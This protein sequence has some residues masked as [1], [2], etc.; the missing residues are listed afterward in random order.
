VGLFDLPLDALERLL[1]EHAP[2]RFAP[3][4]AP[5]S[6]DPG[7]QVVLRN[8]TALELGSPA[9]ASLSLLLWETR[10][11]RVDEDQVLLVGPDLDEAGDARALPLAQI[12]TVSGDLAAKEQVYDHYRALREAAY[13]VHLDGVMLRVQPSQQRIW[14]RVTRQALQRG[15]R[16][17]ELGSAVIERLKALEGVKR[18]QVLLVTKPPRPGGALEQAAA[19]TQEIVDALVKMHDDLL[20]DC[21]DCEFSTICDSV[22]ELRRMHRRLDEER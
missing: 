8:E 9:S 1:A 7:R 20:F 4:P 6:G 21:D 12:V 14:Y 11:D 17:R 3:T 19:L 15:L 13:G 22:D 2:R 16:A 5:S 10:P 18:A